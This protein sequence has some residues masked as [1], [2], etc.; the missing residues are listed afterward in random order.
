MIGFAALF[1]A[2]FGIV[3]NALPLVDVDL[4]WLKIPKIP[5][6]WALAIFLLG[7]IIVAL[8]GGY[9]RSL[10][11]EETHESEVDKAKNQL[12]EALDNSNPKLKG[13]FGWLVAGSVTS[14]LGKETSDKD[15]GVLA[16]FTISNGGAPSI[17][18]GWELDVQL[19][20]GRKVKGVQMYMPFHATVDTSTGRLSFYQEDA[21]YNK[22]YVAIQKG[23]EVSGILRFTFEG[24]TKDDLFQKGVVLTLRFVDFKGQPY[25]CEFTMKG[26]VESNLK[27]L[28]GMRPPV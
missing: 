1:I 17:A 27:Y 18:K 13:E 23:S 28:P 8:E 19:L 22:A 25:S 20:D 16:A 3:Q 21:L 15:V 4:S 12:A 11:L 10:A 7:L 2:A 14:D 24:V 6:P 26:G 5:L 9:R